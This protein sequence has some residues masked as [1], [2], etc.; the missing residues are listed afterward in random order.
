MEQ[1]RGAA[2]GSRSAG[3]GPREVLPSSRL[4]QSLLFG[5]VVRGSSLS[6]PSLGTAA[7]ADTVLATGVGALG[8]GFH[9]SM[10]GFA[11]VGE[12]VQLARG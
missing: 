6:P 12:G 10:S 7:G 2:K 8:W 3:Q 4:H 5:L 9:G 11:M 1:P